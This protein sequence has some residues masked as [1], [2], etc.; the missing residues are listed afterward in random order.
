MGFYYYV[1]KNKTA[2]SGNTADSSYKP[3]F[4]GSTT[5]KDSGATDN[6]T[7]STQT[8]DTSN[9]QTGQIQNSFVETSKFIKIADFAVAGATFFEDQRPLPIVEKAL[10]GGEVPPDQKVIDTK[11]TTKNKKIN[12]QIYTLYI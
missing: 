4:G 11:T 6:N 1:N 8:G 10:D 9:T 7:G 2:T 5:T 12:F 3:F